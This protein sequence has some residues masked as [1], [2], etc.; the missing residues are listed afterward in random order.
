MARMSKRERVAA[1]APGESVD[2]PAWGL[3]R[4]F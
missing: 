1:A 2:R 4:P 3:W